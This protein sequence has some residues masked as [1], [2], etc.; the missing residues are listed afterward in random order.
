MSLYW[1]RARLIT[2]G[3]YSVIALIALFLVTMKP[4]ESQF[5]QEIALSGWT[6]IK[7]D[8]FN[9]DKITE[10]RKSDREQSDLETEIYFIPA[11]QK[12][13]WNQIV[14]SWS[15]T[16][17]PKEL[18]VSNSQI[19]S[20]Y[21]RTKNNRIYLNTCMHSSGK[22]ALSTE[23]FNELA[24]ADLSSRLLPWFFGLSDLRDW[25]CF[26]VNMSVSKDNTT[27]KEAAKLLEQRL[28]TL[29]DEMKFD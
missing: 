20:Y 17:K 6:E 25:N 23:Q 12:E 1:K 4:D 28:F 10:G 11:S 27:Y 14:R 5:P 2:L 29:L 19:G 9:D 13:D 16:L 26:W 3:G 24:N 21:L 7:S 18:A 22:T 15:M 8:R